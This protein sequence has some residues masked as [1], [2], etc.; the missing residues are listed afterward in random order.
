MKRFDIMI[1]GHYP[2]EH[3]KD[4]CPDGEFVDAEIAVELLKALKQIVLKAPGHG[5]LWHG[6]DEIVSARAAIAKATEET[7][8]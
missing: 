7:N 3:C 5:P 8:E 1:E 2:D 6:S 4:Y